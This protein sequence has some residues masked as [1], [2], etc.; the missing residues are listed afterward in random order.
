M[1]THP[2]LADANLQDLELLAARAERHLPVD[3]VVNPLGVGHGAS[4]L[5]VRPQGGHEFAPIDHAV[6]FVEP[7]KKIHFM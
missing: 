5:P 3:L 7:A 6:A 2:V 4:L 1:I